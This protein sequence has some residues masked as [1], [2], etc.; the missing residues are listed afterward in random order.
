MG[1]IKKLSRSSKKDTDKSKKDL[2]DRVNA[3]HKEYK[4]LSLKYKIDLSAELEYKNIGIMTTIKLIDLKA[5]EEAEAEAKRKANL[6]K[7]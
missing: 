2:Q 4:E 7:K 1:L 3:F 5:K 6:G